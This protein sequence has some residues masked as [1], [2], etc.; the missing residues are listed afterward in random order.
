M[1][2]R[3]LLL[4]LLGAIIVLPSALAAPMP[5]MAASGAH[6]VSAQLAPPDA[7]APG[8]YPVGVTRR[9]FSRVSTTTGEP[10]IVETVIWYPATPPSPALS[11]D[12]SLAAPRDAAPER[13]GVPYPVLLW[14]HGNSAAPASYTYLTTHLASHGFVVIA[15][16]HA[17]VLIDCPVPCVASN[18]AAR[19]G[20]LEAMPNRPDDLLSYLLNDS[21]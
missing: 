20:Y 16:T 3:V 4:S 12:E 6:Q 7:G 15:P 21:G 14:S 18:P 8:P 1:K 11:A 10:R 17:G 2:L 9:T 5:P 19:D 13:A